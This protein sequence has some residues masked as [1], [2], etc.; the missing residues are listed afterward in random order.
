M[1][2]K[3]NAAGTAAV[4]QDY[5]WRPMATCPRAAKVQLM[6]PSGVAVYG[7]WNGKDQYWLGW[8]PCPKKPQWMQD[9][10]RGPQE[11]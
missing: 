1:T 10:L 7:T 4:D 8:A 6:N 3:L 2:V 9:G 11:T 5:Y